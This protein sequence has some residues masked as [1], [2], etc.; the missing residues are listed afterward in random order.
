MNPKDHRCS[1][2]DVCSRRKSCKHSKPHT[3][4]RTCSGDCSDGV[5]HKIGNCKEIKK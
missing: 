5:S 4:E 3:W 1:I 2:Y